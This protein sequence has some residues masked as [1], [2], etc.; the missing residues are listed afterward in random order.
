[1]L[2]IG[3]SQELNVSKVKIFCP[4]CEDVYVP[5]GQR[6]PLATKAK[7]CEAGASLDGAYFGGPSFVHM[8]LMDEVD[9]NAILIP[10]KPEEFIPKLYG[11][12]IHQN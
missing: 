4:R 9:K 1:M 11:F 2:P 7:G 12:K 10:S 5:R 3:M 6:H 8:F